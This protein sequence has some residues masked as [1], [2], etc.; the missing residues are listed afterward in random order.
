MV[1]T[2]RWTWVLFSLLSLILGYYCVGK[3]IDPPQKKK[4]VYILTSVSTL[5]HTARELCRLSQATGHRDD[6]GLLRE[7]C[8]RIVRIGGRSASEKLWWQKHVSEREKS[9]GRCY[10]VDLEGERRRHQPRKVCGL[11][12]ETGK[13]LKADSV[14]EDSEGP[15]P[16]WHLDFGPVRPIWTSHLQK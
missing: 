12:L 10:I 1:S 8:N 16:W 4:D 5:P 3:M 13:G 11:S 6:P 9:I 14:L 15:Q 7:H 2:L